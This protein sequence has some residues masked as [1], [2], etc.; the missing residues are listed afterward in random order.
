MFDLHCDTLL[1]VREGGNL[2]SNSFDVSFEKLSE[3]G[4]AGQL[5]AI[6]NQGNLSTKDILDIIKLLK[7][8]ADKSPVAEFCV[9]AQDCK[10]CKAPVSA[11]VSIEGLGNTPD[12]SLEN[13]YEFYDSGVRI[14]GLTWNMDN[15][16]CGG[17]G[18]NVTGLTQFGRD[19]VAKMINLGM[20]IDVSHI[21]DRGFWD[22]AGYPDVKLLATHSNS[23][24]VCNQNR[25][26]TDEQFEAIKSRDGVVG[27][28]LYPLF[29]NGTEVAAVCDLIR[30]IE[31]FCSLGGAK[32]LALGADFDGVDFKMTDID[33]CEKLYIL[34]DELARLNY[35][36]QI[37]EDI[38]Q[39]N[40]IN[41]FELLCI[42]Q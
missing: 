24:T 3:Y 26:I 9:T 2:Q 25:N 21:S 37:I 8:E 7:R 30:H 39:N 40:F 19:V 20:G 12:F 27:L 16:L 28:N 23:R 17:I 35:S 10:N 33:S 31:H 42:G 1:K 34:F 22:I 5:F 29:L 14:S 6:Y 13:L 41:F 15:I 38:S 36:Q 11:F 32:N 18:D 4:K